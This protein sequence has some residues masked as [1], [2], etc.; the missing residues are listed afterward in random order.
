MTTT[1]PATDP[2]NRPSHYV[3]RS[4]RMLIDDTEAHFLGP[5][6]TQAI[7]YLVRAGRKTCDARQDL[8]KAC[9]YVRRLHASRQPSA[10]GPPREDART[11]SEIADDFGLTGFRRTALLCLLRDPGELWRAVHDDDLV[12]ASYLISQEIERLDALA[13]PQANTGA[14]A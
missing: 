9:W 5:H 7:D 6:L 2:V 8:A 4:G 12:T 11:A 10:F 3:G 14:A 1:T 13:L